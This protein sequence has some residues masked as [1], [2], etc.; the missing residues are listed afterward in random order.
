MRWAMLPRWHSSVLLW[1]SSISLLSLAV[2]ADGVEEVGEVHGCRRR[3]RLPVRISLPVE[4][5]DGVAAAVDRQAALLAVEDHV[6]ALAARAAALQLSPS[7][8]IVLRP[9]NSKQTTCVSGVS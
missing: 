9:G 3:C 5:V 7:Q 4:V 6:G 8:V 1:P 2:A